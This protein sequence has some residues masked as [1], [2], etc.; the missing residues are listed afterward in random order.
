MVAYKQLYP[1]G[2]FS[3][4]GLLI[5]GV[6]LR[7]RM[8]SVRISVGY[9]TRQIDPISLIDISQQELEIIWRNYPQQVWRA[10]YS[11]ADLWD[12][13]YSVEDLR[14]QNRDAD[15]LWQNARS[16]ITATAQTLG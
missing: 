12:F 6:G 2:D 5:G 10:I 16:N 1:S 15:Q 7:D 3:M 8:Y 14:E 4:P 11:I 9:G 13:A